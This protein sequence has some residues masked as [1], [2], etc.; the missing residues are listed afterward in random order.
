ML[1]G[2]FDWAI[3]SL[4]ALVST[5]MVLALA[6]QTFFRKGWG[7]TALSYAAALVWVCMGFSVW[8]IGAHAA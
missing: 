7:W 2:Q 5:G 4:I 1:W 6:V 3:Y 8:L